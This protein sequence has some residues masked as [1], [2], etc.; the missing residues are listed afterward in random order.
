MEI[1]RIRAFQWLLAALTLGQLLPA[2][3]A[4]YHVAVTG[5]DGAP[6]SS[7]QPW[8][9]VQKAVSSAAPGDTV[10]IQPGIYR[11]R[12]NVTVSG[13]AAAPIVFKADGPADSVVL[14]ASTLP[15]A[16]GTSMVRIVNRSHVHFVGLEVRNSSGSTDASGFRIE[17]VSDGVQIRN[18]HI[19][20]LT[21]TSAMAI[22]M[23]G[24]NGG[25]VSRAVV[26]SCLIHDC[27]PYPSETVTLNG[28]VFQCTI[29]NSTIRDCNY[30][31]IDL[32]GGERWLQ[33]NTSLVARQNI[34]VGNR[35][36]R[37]NKPFAGTDLAV[38]IYVDGGSDNVVERNYITDCDIGIEVGAENAG[39]T[40]RGNLIRSNVVTKNRDSGL[41]VGAADAA[42][43]RCVANRIFNNALYKNCQSGGWI[44]EILIQYGSQNDFTNNIIWA[45]PD[46]SVAFLWVEEDEN[47]Q[48]FANNC[49]FS[50]RGAA[51][52]SFGWGIDNGY[53]RWSEWAKWNKQD[54][55]GKFANPQFINPEAGDFHVAI[56]SPCLNAGNMN[57]DITGGRGGLDL[58]GMPRVW[59]SRAEIGP[60]EVTYVDIWMRE[61]FPGQIM[62]YTRML[63]DSDGDG[64]CEWMEY[65]SDTDPRSAASFPAMKMETVTVSG[66]KCPRISFPVKDAADTVI[67]LEHCAAL[68][69]FTPV[70]GVVPVVTTPGGVRHLTWTL[71]PFAETQCS[72]FRVTSSFR[73][74][75]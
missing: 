9:T 27:Q 15:A 67:T 56:T 54:G 23:Y 38:G 40:A 7:A 71:P 48:A 30:I 46:T 75:P 59:A 2:A 57:A 74:F 1:R 17:G 26:D 70:T 50:E 18:C 14:D 47:A 22:T 42:Y 4:T 16:G 51:V 3:A 25:A 24:G 69:S 19:H 53:N 60:D 36:E 21:G 58:D 65:S 34:V 28:N 31:G 62:N 37:C 32:I 10:L 61:K 13:T 52:G 6:G 5:S 8:R 29:S 68:H 43:G 63:E 44:P 66:S 35:V 64:F 72:F 55:G 11:E 49:W 73:P 45:I 12:V 33:S 41:I 39:I 20:H